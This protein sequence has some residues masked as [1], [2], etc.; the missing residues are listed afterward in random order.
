MRGW[1]GVLG[2]ILGL[3]ILYALV[4]PGAAG[5]VGGLFGDASKL[6]SNA[7]A[8][9]SDPSTGGLRDFRKTAGTKPKAGKK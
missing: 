2:G 1:R 7:I 9:V 3:S 8:R 4:Q 5:R 6:I